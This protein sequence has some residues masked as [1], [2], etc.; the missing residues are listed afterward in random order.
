M[1][2]VHA[3]RKLFGAGGKSGRDGRRA[4]RLQRLSDRAGAAASGSGW[5]TAGVIAK[6][7]PDGVKERRVI[8]VD[9]HTSEA[10]PSPLDHQ[11]AA[12]HRRAGRSHLSR[13]MSARR[14]RPAALRRARPAV[15]G[16]RSARPRA[17]VSSTQLMAA[18]AWRHEIATVI[19]RRVPIPRLTA[20]PGEAGY[21]YGGVRMTPSALERRRFSRSRR[22]PRSAPGRRST[23]C[24]SISTETGATACPG[25][26]TTARTR[27]RPGDRQHLA[28]R[29]PALPDEASR[30]RPS[31]W[32]WTC[33]RMMPGHVRR[34]PS[35]TGC[36]ECRRPP[37][38]SAPGSNLTFRR[39]GGAA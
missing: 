18:T 1:G 34:Q 22:W 5:N 28:R 19:G 21:V 8:R 37:V 38:R 7:Y 11:G 3:L 35:I 30:A 14:L 15:R 27:P 10:M 23:A 20:W 29:R 6:A 32:R 12:D 36:T 16:G 24:C 17:T 39:W 25:T 9:T 13:R 4:G 31:A 2:L 33:R 26:P